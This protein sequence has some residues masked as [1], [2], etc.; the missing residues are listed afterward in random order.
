MQ[1]RNQYAKNNR[2]DK[3]NCLNLPNEKKHAAEIAKKRRLTEEEK[4]TK[5]QRGQFIFPEHRLRSSSTWTLAWCQ[6][7]NSNAVIAVRQASTYKNR[8]RT[9]I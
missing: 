5:K 3:K 9:P 2:D 1:Q 6:T 7:T 4:S 8:K